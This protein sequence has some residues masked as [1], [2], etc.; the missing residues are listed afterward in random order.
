V[1]EYNFPTNEAAEIHSMSMEFLTWPWM[2][3]FFKEE[4]LKY[5]F[6]HLS[7]AILFLP[8]GVTVDEFQHYVYNNPEDSPAQR[9]S[10]WREIERKYLPHRD[11]GENDYLERGGYWYQ[12]GHIFGSPFYYIDYTLAQVCAFQFWQKAKENKENAW[13][14]Y[15][16]LCYAG[17]SKSFLK[18]VEIANLKSPFSDGCIESVMQSIE[19]WFNI[20]DDT[21]L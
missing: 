21:I 1:P 19:N 9:K 6:N 18:L 16:N 17:G 8:Y 4:E 20:I 5:T 14:D 7:E 11:Y 15:M 2:N 12:Q 3:L 13:T 10:A